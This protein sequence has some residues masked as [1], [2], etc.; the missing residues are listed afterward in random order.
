MASKKTLN[1][2]NL[3]ALGAD[4]LADLILEVTKGNAAAKRRLRLELAGEAGSDDVAREIQKRLVTISRSHSF[5][6]WQGR[7]A[8]AADLNMLRQAIVEQVGK[9]DPVTGFD[10][11]WR[12]CQTNSNQPLFATE[13]VNLPGTK[14]TPL[15]QSSGSIEF[16][17][18]A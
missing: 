5:I 16:E 8:F 4:R 7:N 15:G 17:V 18:F 12:C 3:A 1:A 9:V 13:G 11:I 10:Q 6:D 2:N 14:L